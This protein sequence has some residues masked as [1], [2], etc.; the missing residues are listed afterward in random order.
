MTKSANI[1]AAEKT[2][3][4][5]LQTIDVI[6]ADSQAIFRVGTSKILAAERDIRVLVQ[7]ETL[8]ET[9]LAVSNR[10]ADLLLFEAR[11]SPTPVE[12]VAEIVKR[13]PH[14]KVVIM[15]P[16]AS[17]EETIGYMRYGV[18]G[19]IS[20]AISPDML[21]RCIR[22]VCAG[23]T[24]LDNERV[25][26]VLHAYRAQAAQLKTS[27]SKTRLTEKELLIISG[28]TQGL[29]NKDIAREIGTTEQ[30]VKNYL[31]KIYDKLNI[32]D[33]LELALYCVHNR[34]LDTIIHADS[35]SRVEPSAEA[36]FHP[37]QD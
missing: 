28:V 4:G 17:E 21:V 20:R 1:P 10:K 12:A 37:A 26:W 13:D 8:G 14:L 3:T 25:N 18:R 29:R 35:E 9:L 27:N 6:L 5:I 2:E 23:E 7:A 32:S 24:W 19:I 33:R 11:I 15:T 16:D 36:P 34:I 22:K 31:R 30:V